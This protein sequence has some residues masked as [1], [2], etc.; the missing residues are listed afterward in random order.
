M[1]VKFTNLLSLTRS[2]VTQIM[3]VICILRKR[4]FSELREKVN[5]NQ[6]S[7][8]YCSRGTNLQENNTVLI[9][10][11]FLLSEVYK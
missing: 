7:C 1:E 11:Q 2:E 8:K 9:Q 6:T 3:N 4:S 5:T 10:A